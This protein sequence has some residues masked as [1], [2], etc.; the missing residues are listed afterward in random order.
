M[1]HDYFYKYTKEMEE[2]LGLIQ[3]SFACP[4]NFIFEDLQEMK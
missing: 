4:N 3:D 2:F 1:N